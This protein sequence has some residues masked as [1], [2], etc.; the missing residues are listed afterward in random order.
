MGST[1]AE[2][3]M[4]TG[5]DRAFLQAPEGG[6]LP[7]SST[8]GC[9][10]VACSTIPRPRVTAEFDEL[11]WRV[12]LV[13]GGVAT[14]KTVAIA[15]WFQTLEDS[16][17]EWLTLTRA[18]DRP[19]RFWSALLA[20][21]D[22]AAPGAFTRSL[23][24][25]AGNRPSEEIVDALL[26]E[27]S[28]LTCECVLILDDVHLLRNIEIWRGLIDLVERMP[29][30]AHIVMTSRCDPP[31]PLTLWSARGWLRQVR[32]SDLAFTIAETTEL[33]GRLNGAELTPADVQEIWRRTEGWIASLTILASQLRRGKEVSAVLRDFSG[34]HPMIA[35]LLMDE[36]VNL[37]TD[38]IV[39]FML[40]T[41]VLNMLDPELC[42]AASSRSD[43]REVLRLLDVDLPFMTRTDSEG[44][45]RY[46]PLL[47]DALR[48]QL[49]ARL[50][51]AAREIARVAAGVCA[52]RGDTLDAVGY[53]VA[54]GDHDAAFSMALGTALDL[55]VYDGV[56]AA[57]AWVDLIRPELAAETV[58][59]MLT[60]AVGLSI[61]GRVE[62]ALTWTERAG[63]RIEQCPQQFTRESA[64]A[65]A[66]RLHAFATST[67]MGDGIGAGRRALATAGQGI[68]L[69]GVPR[70][71]PDLARAYLLVDKPEAARRVLS[72]HADDELARLVDTPGVT[73][74]VLVRRGELCEALDLATEAQI[75]SRT[76]GTR[77]SVGIL[78]ACL[79]EASVLAERNQIAE[80]QL[81]VKEL[82][83]SV[84]EHT[85]A[86]VYR[87]LSSLEGVRLAVAHSG[88]EEGLA[89]VNEVR[90]HLGS[91]QRPAL[92]TLI[93][94]VAARWSLEAGLLRSAEI[95]ISTLPHDHCQHLLLSARLDLARDRPDACMAKLNELEFQ[96]RRRHLEQ[97]LLRVR[98]AVSV[99][100]AKTSS[101]VDSAIR[102]AAPQRI[103]LA[104]LEEGPVVTRLVRSACGELETSEAQT[105]AQALGAP[106]KVRSLTGQPLLLS[107]RE[108]SVLRYLTTRLTNR[109]IA[110]EC[111]MSVN[112]VKTHLRHI[113]EKLGVSTRAAAGERAR[114]LGLL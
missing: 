51:G 56:G 107:D 4:A 110:D 42:N 48:S 36:V 89:I 39:D 104:I 37:Q 15:Q 20:A 75:A 26:V 93:D 64:V 52:G 103:V 47:A 14:G 102:L 59:L 25:V 55:S 97:E 41:S 50:P 3:D 88:P 83:S 114:T 24:L 69:G 92:T 77:G 23:S 27:L 5:M 40:R 112:T 16:A 86:L 113:Y 53:L 72:L 29:I 63:I 98:A 35:D 109:E 94:V 95:L 46:H 111:F 99:N 68:D 10:R 12:A 76:L 17:C 33:L 82:Q 80:A 62:E 87:V 85:G 30:N 90:E 34:H 106:P 7:C 66:L 105:L 22:R 91:R 101:Y 31:I 79:A 28:L 67:G 2:Q 13:T 8:I 57:A 61:V 9:P 96:D 73:A 78:D 54:S 45:Y 81:K 60:L 19:A 6:G 58:P 74:R 11:D 38:E 44:A 32:Q 71:R 49:D 84:E 21:L 18:D 100:D 70:I 43:S 1:R 65:D 108:Q